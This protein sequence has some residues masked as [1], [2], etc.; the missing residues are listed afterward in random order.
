MATSLVGPSAAL[1][2][3]SIYDIF[4]S[5]VSEDEGRLLL[6]DGTREFSTGAVRTMAEHMAGALLFHFKQH[7]ITRPQ[8]AALL[9]G[10]CAERVAAILALLKLGC[11]F[12]SL[13]PTLP[14][15]RIKFILKKS[16]VQ[17]ALVSPGNETASS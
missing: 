13:S 2:E 17:F 9:M 6:F 1:P 4:S 11:A 3:N 16:D 8:V 15:S 10:Q 5:R 14:A 12:V 7:S